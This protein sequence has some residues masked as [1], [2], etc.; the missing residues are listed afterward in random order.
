[1]VYHAKEIIN[2]AELVKEE[3][4]KLGLNYNDKIYIAIREFNMPKKY[5]LPI[6][7]VGKANRIVTL[8]VKKDE[9]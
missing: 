6:G 2:K 5:L 4:E 3:C 1:M 8:L 9:V 7:A